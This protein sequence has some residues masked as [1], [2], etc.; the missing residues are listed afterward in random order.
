V[1]ICI[2]NGL[3]SWKKMT[4][5]LYHHGEHSTSRLDGTL[6]KIDGYIHVIGNMRTRGVE[7]KVI[8]IFKKVNLHVYIQHTVHYNA[9]FY[10]S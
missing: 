8:F 10:Y 1:C 5:H 6:V 4:E 3:K 9:W 7:R 2:A